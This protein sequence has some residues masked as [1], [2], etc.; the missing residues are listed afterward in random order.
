MCGADSVPIS[1]RIAEKRRAP[2]ASGAICSGLPFLRKRAVPTCRFG[3]T[4]V[5][6]AL[7]FMNMPTSTKALPTALPAE[8]EP[9]LVQFSLSGIQSF[10]RTARTTRDL[11]IGSFLLSDLAFSAM[12]PIIEQYGPTAILYPD[13]RGNPRMDAW[14]D[15]AKPQWNALRKDLEPSLFGTDATSFA[16]V[17]PNS[18]VAV[19]PLGGGEFP[20]L[21]EL[22]DKAKAR[23]QARWKS[24]ADAVQKWLAS[25]VPATAGNSW[26]GVWE[27]QHRH[28][29]VVRVRWTAVPW[30]HAPRMKAFVQSG[31]LPF[32]DASQLLPQETEEDRA[33]REQR[34]RRFTPWVSEAV[35]THVEKA[36]YA[37]G[38]TNANLFQ[39][40]RGFDYGITNAQ[41]RA[42]H[43]VRKQ[44]TPWAHAVENEQ[45]GVACTLCGQRMALSVDTESQSEHVDSLTHWARTFWSNE[46]LDPEKRGAERL[47]AVCSMK[48]F[49]VVAGGAEQGINRLWANDDDRKQIRES[50]ARVPFPSTTA[51]C[52]QRYIAT[53]CATSDPKVAQAIERVVNTHRALGLPA[54]QF[55]HCLRQ[56]AE[57]YD[58]L[59]EGDV[60]RDFLM[61]E[62]QEML[63]PQA[64]EARVAAAPGQE[65]EQ[66]NEH[67]RAICS[68]LQVVKER[69]HLA[70]P[71]TRLAVIKVDGDALSHLLTGEPD[72]LHA[73]WRDV[74]HPELVEK[75]EAE[76]DVPWSSLLDAKRLVGPTLHAF[77]TRALG[78][79]AHRIAPWV[80]EQEFH[81]RLIYAGGTMCWRSRPLTRRCSLWLACSNCFLRLGSWMCVQ[82]WTHGPGDV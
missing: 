9:W 3:T 65:R 15:E 72:R 66:G 59:P 38:R 37:F 77:V 54:T 63:Y 33:L 27:R 70:P 46:E 60:R 10:I 43:Q 35:W 45:A 30:V 7:S 6:S 69:L 42:V 19:V 49:L 82:I 78:A 75:L 51:I 44:S 34:T 11:W 20:N 18:F 1:S 17:V 81:G 58:R 31:A 39:M 2:K 23:V 79:F 55:P 13:L 80:V 29:D 61:R 48:R 21:R 16:A 50:K 24:H 64:M 32:Q 22:A 25:V 71:P 40:E 52:A 8:R 41:L 57:T 76:K 53:L 4:R 26:K 68:L 62:P 12:L 74:I 5:A 73:R 28:A 56:L 67:V 36:R 14:L 47:C